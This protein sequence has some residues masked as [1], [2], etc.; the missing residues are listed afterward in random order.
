MIDFLDFYK[1]FD[2][3]T[4]KDLEFSKIRYLLHEYCVEETAKTMVLE[5]QPYQS[6][7]EV[8]L[9]LSVISD[10]KTIKEEEH[11]SFPRLEFKEL[12][13]ELV[14][15]RIKGTTLEIES[16]VKI[17][18]A[19]LLINDM[20]GFL[21]K[22]E[23]EF[24]F[25]R[26]EFDSVFITKDIIAPIENVLDKRFKVKDDASKV[27]FEI[28]QQTKSTRK[29]V[30]RNFDRALK[31]YQTK[32]YL[33]DTNESFLNG[34]RVL[35][36]V[37][38]YK[39]M[40]GGKL[41]GASKS[42]HLTYVEP[43]ENSMLNNQLEQL[44]E[45]ERAEVLRI[46]K[47]LT[48]KIRVNFD[49]V[50]EYQNILVRLDFLQAK[51]KFGI[52]INANQPKS[53]VESSIDLIDAV[54][55]LLF[56]TNQKEQKKTLSQSILMDKFSR[57][58]VISGPNAGGKSIT[59][60]TIG[61][62]QLMYQSGLLI[63]ANEHS[64]MGW[65]QKILTD[66]GDNQSIEN[67]LSTYSYRLKRMN[68]FLEVANKRTLLLLDEFGTGS[69][70]DLGGA[71]AEVF[72]ETLYNKK[73]FAVITTHYANIKLKASILRN[74]VNASMLFDT[75]SLTPLFK[76][77]VGQP[78]SSFTF[79]VAKINGISDEL[80]AEAKTRLDLNRVKMDELLTELQQEKS[81]LQQAKMAFKIVEG[82]T[83]ESEEFYHSKNEKLAEKLKK[84]QEISDKN[85]KLITTGNKFQLF[86]KKYNTKNKKAN[87]KL[88]E[89]ITKYIAVEKTKTEESTK[90]SILKAKEALPKKKTKKAKKEKL[91]K[92]IVVGSQVRLKQGGKQ[93]GE[94]LEI[95]K[96]IAT[97]LFGLFKTKVKKEK[98]VCLKI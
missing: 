63:P 42:G 29:Q 3:Q 41:Y 14:V 10:Y 46:L 34:R 83:L 18:D 2:Q 97:V 55:P 35:S 76:L 67:E 48:S 32:G 51:T 53:T 64:T 82:K 57:M 36:V 70:P 44:E 81:E 24:S 40:I 47:E 1:M 28:R 61:L 80:I 33:G 90:L 6:Q 30:N 84:T 25:L 65:F 89:E 95:N 38:S 69:D 37:S 7:E 71:L 74:A 27:L 8:T 13:E 19:S 23:D 85:N 50:K 56:L 49:L 12:K 96:E 72:F 94:V 60:K 16:I 62:L 79:E 58:L 9:E 39:R 98:L 17:Y 66:I 75:E 4:I 54:H 68:Y 59:L 20:L 45:D 86:I 52:R 87:K 15:L 77:S 78:G 91:R 92:P 43:P 11:S 22:R 88:I 31:K 93:I 5:I 26:A 73:S 21:K